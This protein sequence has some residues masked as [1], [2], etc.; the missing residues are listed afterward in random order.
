MIE[1]SAEER[2][3]LKELSG[4]PQLRKILDRVT[5]EVAIQSWSPNKSVDEEVKK[6]EWIYQSGLADGVNK[7]VKLL[8]DG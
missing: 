8:T 4:I 3:F 6:S 5:A 1:L 7:V 2:L